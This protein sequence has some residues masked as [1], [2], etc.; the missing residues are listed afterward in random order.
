MRC[1]ARFA[2]STVLL[3][4]AGTASTTPIEGWLD[5]IPAIDRDVAVKYF[6][7]HFRIGRQSLAISDEFFQHSLGLDFMRMRRSDKVH[8]DVRVNENHERVPVP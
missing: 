7:Q 5:C 4:T 1:A 6:L 8:W 3:S 2:R